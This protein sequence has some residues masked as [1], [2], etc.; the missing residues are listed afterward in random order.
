[1]QTLEPDIVRHTPTALP[2]IRSRGLL[3]PDDPAFIS[4]QIRKLLDAN[5]YELREAGAVRALVHDGD[6]ALE[7]G[8]GI[9]FMSTL[10]VKSCKAARVHSFE[11]N[12]RLIPYIRRVHALNGVADKVEVSNAVLGGRKGKTTFY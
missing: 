9:G 8:G 1:M 7:L 6:V 2:N 12:P 5:N 11:A 3:F 4:P 10:M